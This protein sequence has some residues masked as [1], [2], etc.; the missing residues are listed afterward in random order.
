MA[1]P[2][3]PSRIVTKSDSPQR[4]TTSGSGAHQH[5][6][7]VN[8]H[9]AESPDVDRAPAHVSPPVG[10]PQSPHDR[11]VSASDMSDCVDEHSTSDRNC[12]PIILPR[13]HRARCAALAALLAVRL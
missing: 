9:F 6:T 5:T 1:L 13:S 11:S 3:P 8:G 12:T 7:Q 2:Q 10:E 4:H